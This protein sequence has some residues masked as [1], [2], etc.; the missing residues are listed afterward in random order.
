[1]FNRRFAKSFNRMNK[2]TINQINTNETIPR[3]STA[4]Y[5]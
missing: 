5:E 2:S 4:C 1:M 3:L